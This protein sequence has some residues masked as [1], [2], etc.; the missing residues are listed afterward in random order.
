MAFRNRCIG[1]YG[2]PHY[3]PAF[4]LLELGYPTEVTCSASTVYSGI[5]KEA[6]FPESIPPSSKLCYKFKLKDGRDL[7]LYWMDGGIVPDRPDELDA[8][9]NMN[10]ALADVPE[11][12]DYEGG[13]LFIGSKGKVS[14]GWGGSHPRLLPLSLNKDV[15]V[16]KNIP[17]SRAIWM[18]TGGNGLM[19]ALRVMAMPRSIPV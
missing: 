12:N 3:W 17:V 5:F 15:N 8:D 4:K 19:H 18:A 10:E 16:P 9:V 11:E 13:S 7:K 6:D 14:C 2:V 1:R